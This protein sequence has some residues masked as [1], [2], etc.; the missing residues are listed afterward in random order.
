MQYR[1]I[2]IPKIRPL[3]PL[4]TAG[5]SVQDGRKATKYMRMLTLI[6]CDTLRKKGSKAVLILVLFDCP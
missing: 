1:S 3:G 4:G 6:L 2:R 5:V